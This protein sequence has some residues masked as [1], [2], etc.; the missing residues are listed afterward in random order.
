MDFSK[1]SLGRRFV[2]ENVDPLEV[3]QGTRDNALTGGERQ[4]QGTRDKR[5]Q[6]KTQ[7]SSNAVPQKSGV[8]YASES[9]QELRRMKELHRMRE[10][11]SHDWRK[12]IAEGAEENDESR[13]PYV[14]VMPRTNHREKK[15]ALQG[16][17]AKDQKEKETKELGEEVCGKKVYD[18]TKP[19][20]NLRK[21]GAEKVAKKMD[22]GPDFDQ[23]FGSFVDEQLSIDQQMK[24]S[25]EAAKNRNPNPDHKAIR[26]KMLA[27]AVS[28]DTRTDAQKMTDATGPRPG[29]N[30]RG[31]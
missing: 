29:S 22:E 31:D 7:R 25:R 3:A 8:T 15:M 20:G 9:Y 6:Q 18:T 10:M 5:G 11:L 26:G 1:L 16:K 19:G 4:N 13:H 30:Y 24:I 27:K 14:D 23:V 21:K 12:D 2:P 17:Q 28:K